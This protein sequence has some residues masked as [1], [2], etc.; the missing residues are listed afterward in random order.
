MTVREMENGACI[1]CKEDSKP[2]KGNFLPHKAVKHPRF[3]DHLWYLLQP[4]WFT[5]VVLIQVGKMWF[6][7]GMENVCE[8]TRHQAAISTNI[9]MPCFPA[10]LAL[11]KCHHNQQ[12]SCSFLALLSQVS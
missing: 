6:C 12:F 5:G 10:F 7:N 2:R 11:D 3:A 4:L 9:S 1:A 8:E